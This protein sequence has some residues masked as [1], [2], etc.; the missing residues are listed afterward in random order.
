MTALKNLEQSDLKIQM[1]LG[2]ALQDVSPRATIA[3]EITGPDHP[4]IVHDISHFL[5]ERD[6][7]ISEMVSHCEEGAMSGGYVFHS[8]ISASIPKLHNISDVEDA[9][10]GLAHSLNVDIT[11]DDLKGK[12]TRI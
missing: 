1:T 11:L 4:G 5:A 7:N 12:R 3:L 6:I 9:L 10:D 8:N 2:D